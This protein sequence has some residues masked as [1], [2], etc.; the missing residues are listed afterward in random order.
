MKEDMAQNKESS[1]TNKSTAKYTLE[2][3]PIENKS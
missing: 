2:A 3:L 1:D